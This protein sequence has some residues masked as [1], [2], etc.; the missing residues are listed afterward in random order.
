MIALLDTDHVSL[1]Q[2]GHR[3]VRTR[4]MAA[5]PAVVGISIITVEEQLRGWLAVVRAATTPEARETA[6]RRLRMAVE[7][8][9][10]QSGQPRLQLRQRAA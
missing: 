1:D 8:F 2:R 6:Y 9:A 7:Y 10:R 5:G 3:L 4:V